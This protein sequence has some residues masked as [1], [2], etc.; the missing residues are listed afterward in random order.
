MSR[1]KRFARS[2]LSGYAMLGANTIYTL[3]SVPLAL[4][5]L[6]RPEFGLWA[7]TMQ[8]AGYIGLIDAGM[9][10]SIS[11]I[12]IDYKD[13][14]VDGKY[15]STI[16]TGALVGV[17]QGGLVVLA[18]LAV[19]FIAGS[20]LRVPQELQ[21]KFFWLLLG[22]CGVLGIAF[23]TRVFSHLLMAHQRVDITNYGQS[24]L[25][26]VGLLLMWSGF[27]AGWGVFSFLITQ[28]VM[29]LGGAF[30]NGLGCLRL[31]LFPEADQ[32]GAVTWEKFKELFAFGRDMFLYSI[33]MQFVTASQTVLLTR[34]LGL[35]VAAVWSICTRTYTMLTMLIWRIL[36][37]SAPVVAEMMVR[38]EREWLLKRFKDLA[39][40]SAG[41]SVFSAVLFG[42]C[43]G[44]FVQIWTHGKI[45]WSPINNWLLALWFVLCT[46]MRI[47]IMLA[48][49][50][51]RFGFLRYVFLLEGVAFILL[52]LLLQGHRG[53]TG[54]LIF[55]ILCTATFSLPYGLW[56][57]RR[58]FDLT[59][60]DLA[61]CYRPTWRLAWRFI[62]VAVGVW[63]LT[64]GLSPFWQL[65]I[66]VG[67]IGAF[68]TV[69][70]LRYGLSE[71]LQMD[72]AGK[73]PLKL[74]PI[75]LRVSTPDFASVL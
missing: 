45:D 16:K 24:V 49:N 56:R 7:L 10:G 29:G 70:L 31:K 55:S 18:G 42:A 2:L 1:L 63:W 37:Y 60:V 28:A 38:G 66:N 21:S 61:R 54:M 23:A 50:S 73:L 4:H 67:V 47:H 41:A 3:A 11:R 69:V 8:L 52:N 19:A 71:S 46:V 57:T 32:W 36:D 39:I 64:N 5:Y 6:S 43:N 44:A 58:Y 15:G 13:H 59:S 68:G 53:M 25:F 17:V 35:D 51:K 74:R 72:I 9:S 40:V 22:Q 26:G 75:F 33:G 14:R 20:L 62:P 48:G 30:V 27:A 12:L 34:F 65:A